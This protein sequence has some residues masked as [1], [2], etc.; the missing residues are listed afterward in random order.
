MSLSIPLAGKAGKSPLPSGVLARNTSSPKIL[1]WASLH[2]KRP[3]LGI[4]SKFALRAITYSTGRSRQEFVSEAVE[5]P[6]GRLL[7][8]KEDAG[9]ASGIKVEG[10][11]DGDSGK[12][13]AA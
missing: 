2:A 7:V 11:G 3:I 1:N 5:I 9:V 13:G 6:R 8:V 4:F 10:W 12:E